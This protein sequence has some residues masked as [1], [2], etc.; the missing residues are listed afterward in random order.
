MIHDVLG[1]LK[2]FRPKFVKQYVNMQETVD[3]AVKEFIDEVQQGTFPGKDH[4][5]Q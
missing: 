3:R 5:F 2:G 4:I 1:L